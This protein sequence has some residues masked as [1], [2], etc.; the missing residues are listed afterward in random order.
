MKKTTRTIGASA[1]MLTSSVV[2]NQAGT[3]TQRVVRRGGTAQ[4]LCSTSR[5]VQKCG[6]YTL[7]CTM[8]RSARNQLLTEAIRYTLVTTFTDRAGSQVRTSTNG[9]LARIPI[10]PAPAEPVTG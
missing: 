7:T 2:A 8:G 5:E 10:R 1:V 4:T 9:K 3:N 6:T